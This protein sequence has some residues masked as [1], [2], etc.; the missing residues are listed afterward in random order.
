MGASWPPRPAAGVW[1]AL[2]GRLGSS[3]DACPCR[4]ASLPA[5]LA[6]VV[7]WQVPR[8]A[9]QVPAAQAPAGRAGLQPEGSSGAQGWA[10]AAGCSS[11][12][13]T[14]YACLGRCVRALP[15]PTAPVPPHG[16]VPTPAGATL[17]PFCSENSDSIYRGLFGR[18][19]QQSTYV[20]TSCFRTPAAA[21]ALPTA[22]PR[23]VNAKSIHLSG[24]TEGEAWCVR[25]P[26]GRGSQP[27][28]DA[29][30]LPSP[31]PQGGLPA[32]SSSKRQA[33]MPSCNPRP[34]L[35][36]HPPTSQVRDY[37]RLC[38]RLAA[39]AAR[40][41]AGAGVGGG[42]RG[43]CGARGV[44]GRRECGARQLPGGV[45]AGPRHV[46]RRRAGTA[47]GAAA[48]GAAVRGVRRER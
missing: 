34:P 25:V 28:L 24:V 45:P 35:P 1:A 27:A 16:G 3:S 21:A 19:W 17:V 48:A 23:M 41:E 43:G 4:A 30:G 18:S 9:G 15:L 14:C 8:Q 2:H 38:Q 22:A 32:C 40:P 46:W 10:A 37:R 12:G 6:P 47:A 11:G 5:S 36:I 20:R 44:C 29:C 13:S 33:C 7:C 42:G 31:P 39:G 26:H